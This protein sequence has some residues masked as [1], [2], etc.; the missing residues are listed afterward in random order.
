MFQPAER[1]RREFDLIAPSSGDEWSHN[2]HY[3][4]YLL[5]QLPAHLESALDV[6]CGIGTF[7]R[8]LAARA[9]RVVGLDLSPEMIRCARERAAAFLNIDYQVAD[10]LETDLPSAAFDCIASIATLHHMALEP[11]LMKLKAA[12]KPGGT[13]LILDLYQGEGISDLPY[14]AL[15]IPVHHLLRVLRGHQTL[16]QSAAAQQAWQEHGAGDVYPRVSEVRQIAAAHFPGA[17]V[18]KHVLWRYSLVWR[19]P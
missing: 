12:L 17:Q 16:P 8:L 3:H 5:R 14:R 6:G 10:V 2:S 13:L 7:S 4:P 1:I 19:K 15:G 18:R 11:V 9:D